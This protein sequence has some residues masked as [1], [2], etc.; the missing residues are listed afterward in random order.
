MSLPPTHELKAWLL[1]WLDDEHPECESGVD[2]IAGMFD[3]LSEHLDECQATDD[4]YQLIIS[5]CLQLVLDYLTPETRPDI[6]RSCE[7]R[8]HVTIRHGLH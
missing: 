2:L 5:A 7:Q 1:E 3:G 8:L 4:E 6:L